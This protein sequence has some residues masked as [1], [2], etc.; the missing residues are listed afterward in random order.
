M[1]TGLR[2]FARLEM[3]ELELAAPEGAEHEDEPRQPLA[4]LNHSPVR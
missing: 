3:A 1:R 4:A 2:L